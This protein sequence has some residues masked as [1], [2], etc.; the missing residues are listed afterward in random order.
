MMMRITDS[1]VTEPGLSFE[2]L[3]IF[4]VWPLHIFLKLRLT[5]S[6]RLCEKFKRL[7]NQPFFQQESHNPSLSWEDWIFAE[8]RRR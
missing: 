3:V 1:S 5:L 8:S 2:I 7:C 6:E 4:Q